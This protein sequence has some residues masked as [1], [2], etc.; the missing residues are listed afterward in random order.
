VILAAGISR[1]ASLLDGLFH[2]LLD[3]AAFEHIVHQDLATGQH[4]NP[5]NHPSYFATA[6]FHTSQEL[7]EEAREAGWLLRVLLVND[8][9]TEPLLP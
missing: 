2:G 1:S 6:Y 3:D 7:Q 8:P 9:K 5:T 4:R